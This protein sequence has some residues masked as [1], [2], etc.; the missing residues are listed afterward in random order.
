LLYYC[1]HKEKYP[2]TNNTLWT[3]LELVVKGHV[4]SK[5]SLY[6]QYTVDIIRTSCQRSRSIKRQASPFRIKIRNTPLLCPRNKAHIAY[7]G[8]WL[9]FVYKHKNIYEKLLINKSSDIACWF[10][11]CFTLLHVHGWNFGNLLIR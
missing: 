6:K 4:L 9:G 7:H 1:Y 3:Y 2:S 5:V 10:P 8:P 11:V